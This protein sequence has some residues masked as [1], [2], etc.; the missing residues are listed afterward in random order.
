MPRAGS[1]KA[2]AG[3]S[4]GRRGKAAPRPA[5]PLAVVPLAS[6]DG[7]TAD[8]PGF[9][10]FT[11][12]Y[13]PRLQ[14][15]PAPY[16]PR[17]MD[18]GSGKRLRE[19]L[20]RGLVE[21]LVWNEHNGTLI[22]GHQRLMQMDKLAGHPDERP[23]YHVPCS[24]VSI[25]DPAEEREL[26]IRLNNPNLMGT[27]DFGA[28]QQMF[29]DGEANPFSAGFELLDLE[30]D[31]GPDL[32]QQMS[33]AWGETGVVSDEQAETV[34]D[35]EALLQ[36]EDKIQ[37]IKAAKRVQVARDQ[38]DLDPGHV[39][40]VVYR[41]VTDLRD[42]LKWWGVDRDKRFIDIDTF[43]AILEAKYREILTPQ[44][45]AEVLEEIGATNHGPLSE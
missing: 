20:Q 19:S 15:N 28:L 41:S 5:E 33:E 9:V 26:N 31:F 8:L 34:G 43:S 14:I 4:G 35:E 36:A 17:S 29:T 18:V 1:G 38:Q 32:A 39:L 21:P 7:V 40:H 44:I 13:V 3:K 27:Y 37:Q 24:V 12:A 30:L 25:T 45:R 22:G 6:P 11:M 42:T 2:A 23:D 16:N 10:K